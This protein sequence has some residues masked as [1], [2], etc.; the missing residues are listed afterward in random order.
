MS[1][2]VRLVEEAL[3]VS[4]RG[5]LVRT[6]FGREALGQGTTISPWEMEKVNIG[7]AWA[8][9]GGRRLVKELEGVHTALEVL[10]D[11]HGEVEVLGDVDGALEVEDDHVEDRTELLLEP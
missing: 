6:L 4:E 11:A 1:S 9:C 2:W 10:Q 7:T 3:M 5:G 8:W